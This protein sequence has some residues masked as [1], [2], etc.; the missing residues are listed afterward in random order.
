MATAK[1]KNKES[2]RKRLSLQKKYNQR[3]T[4][5][6]QGREAFHQKDYINAA[7]K[8]KEY[9]QILADLNEIEDVYKLNP[10]MFDRKTQITEMLLISH[11]YWEI[12]RINEVAPELQATYMKALNQFVKFTVNQPYQVLNAEMLRKFI[13]KTAKTSNKKAELNY[14]YQQIFIQSKKC[15]VATLCYGDQHPITNELRLF[16]QCLEKSSWGLKFIELYYR[17]STKLVDY[18]EARP[19]QKDYF[20]HLV[21]P[22]LFCLAKTSRLSIFK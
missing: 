4:I 11:V 19:K 3:I 8:Y 15:Y 14:A 13:K 9:L 12:S 10:S 21:R 22:F 16:K 18:L 6:R 17:S 7:A 5:A 2:Q 1:E 20:N